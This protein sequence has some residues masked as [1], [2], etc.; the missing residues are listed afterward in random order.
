MSIHCPKTLRNFESSRE[1]EDSV[2]SA[3]GFRQM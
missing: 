2:C 3:A 1:Y